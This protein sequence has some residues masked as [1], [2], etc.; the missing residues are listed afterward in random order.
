MGAENSLKHS[1]AGSRRG[2]LASNAPAI[3]A[4]E[5]SFRRHCDNRHWQGYERASETLP[6]A[7][8]HI[9]AMTLSLQIRSVTTDHVATTENAAVLATRL[10]FS[11]DSVIALGESIVAK[12]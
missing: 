3:V 8:G 12:R 4:I 10:L 2:L 1:S 6:R 5:A 7:G 11:S 9:A